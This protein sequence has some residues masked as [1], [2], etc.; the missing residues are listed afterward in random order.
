MSRPDSDNVPRQG[1]AH[2]DKTSQEGWVASSKKTI[3][4]DF[5]DHG[6]FKTLGLSSILMF[7]VTLVPQWIVFYVTHVLC[8]LSASILFS[9]FSGNTWSELTFLSDER[10][11][12]FMWHRPATV[13]PRD[14]FKRQAKRYDWLPSLLGDWGQMK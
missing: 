3:A 13:L 2:P 5:L 7:S 1:L 8:D 9:C 6:T 12:L 14:T 4:A 11:S 10:K